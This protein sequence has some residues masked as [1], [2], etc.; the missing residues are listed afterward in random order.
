MKKRYV[1][2]QKAWI[3]I[4]SGIA[5][6]LAVISVILNILRLCEVGSRVSYNHPLDIIATVV[7]LAVASVL[8]MF[9]AGSGYSFAKKHFVVNLGFFV[10]MINYQDIML[11]RGDINNTVLFVYFK[12]GKNA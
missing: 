4:L 11:V 1:Y 7:M 8:L 9:V 2:T 3:V 12:P 10:K 6:L 5:M